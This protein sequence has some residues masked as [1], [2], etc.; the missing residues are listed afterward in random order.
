[1]PSAHATR[2]AS[3]RS[4]SVQQRPVRP[5]SPEW[6]QSC[7][8][9]PMTSCPSSFRSRAA[10]E[11][12]TP[13]D[14]ATA[15]RIRK[16]V[17]DPGN[18]KRKTGND[19]TARCFPSFSV[20]RLPLNGPGGLSGFRD[21]P[22]QDLE[23]PVDLLVGRQARQRE[24]HDALRLR[25]GDA[26]REDGRRGGEGPAG[27]GASHRY[28]DAFQVEPDQQRLSRQPGKLDRGGVRE[29][30]PAR[31]D[32]L[33]PYDGVQEPLFQPVSKPGVPGAFGEPL[34]RES[35]GDA[36]AND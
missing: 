33:G 16:I 29:P 13:P 22:R 28:R 11:E 34:A 31:P 3:E 6:S 21:D 7:I 14:M 23:N 26:E 9:S 1:M 36:E 24:A 8:E 15:M 27:A 5:A 30:A 10:T 32:R 20:S 18:G 19:L 12:S 2:R 25:R 4:S 17:R 35:G